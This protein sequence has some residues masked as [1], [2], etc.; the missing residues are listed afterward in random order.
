MGTLARRGARDKRLI[1]TLIGDLRKSERSPSGSRNETLGPKGL[2][3]SEKDS[4]LVQRKFSLFVISLLVLMVFFIGVLSFRTIVIIA[5]S[6]IGTFLV[7]AALLWLLET[8]HMERG[9]LKKIAKGIRRIL[10]FVD[11][12][13]HGSMFPNI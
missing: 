11:D 8:Y 7:L 4:K 9:F 13:L 5:L 1:K 6:I 2:Y 10:T 12:V 3:S